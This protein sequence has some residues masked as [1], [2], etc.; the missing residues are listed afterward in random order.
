MVKAAPGLPSVRGHAELQN[1]IRA[2][3]SSARMPQSLL[4]YG[5]EGVGKRTM[6]LWTAALLQC[7]DA[8][9]PCGECRSCRLAARIEHPDIHYHFP[10]PRPKGGGS[11]KK[12][13]EKIETQRQERLARMRDE[14][15]VVIDEDA[16]TGIY[17][18]AVENM[19]DQASRRPA[20]G[21]LV[22][23]VIAEADRMVPQSASP[24]AANAF[25]KL[26]E[27]PPDFAYIILTSSRPHALLPTIR[28]RTA[29]LRVPPIPE[30]EVVGF[31]ES[32]RGLSPAEAAILA[33]RAEGSIGRALRLSEESDADAGSAADRLLA[34]ALLGGG[35]D[36]F[37]AAGA[38]TAQG[39]RSILAPALEDLEDRLRDLLCHATG[40]MHLAHD[41]E[42]T[43]RIV[44]RFPVD[45][46]GLLAALSAVEEARQSAARNLN[47]QS[48][49][50]VLLED[51][52]RALSGR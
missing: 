14:P 27:E 44:N 19:R 37:G 17:L 49:V 24:E 48:T 22:V 42:K 30:S 39:A 50:S 8:P 47:P 10:M 35:A 43:A 31:L 2:S 21:S 9:A 28:S 26:L 45:E 38:Y 52:S 23:F 12:L 13:R 46:A 11:R 34:A 4:L 32:E 15:G 7:D 33:R 16:V 25:L 20:M 40:A 36:R 6:A 5:A 51:M 3:V 18:T 41:A 1:R 29:T